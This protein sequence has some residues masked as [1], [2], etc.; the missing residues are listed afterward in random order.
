LTSDVELVIYLRFD[1][2]DLV[3]KNL[4]TSIFE[5]YRARENQYIIGQ[6]NFSKLIE[7]GWFRNSNMNII[8]LENG[9]DLE[10]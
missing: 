7:S 10:A 3:D 9:E 1:N 4:F 8:L 6:I 5:E 2:P